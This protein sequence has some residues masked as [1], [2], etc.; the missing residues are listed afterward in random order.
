MRNALA[1]LPFCLF[2]LAVAVPV[3]AQAPER[4]D[5]FGAAIADAA[6]ASIPLPAPRLPPQSP[7]RSR[8]PVGVESGDSRE[9]FA[10]L[11]GAFAGGLAGLWVGCAIG[12]CTGDWIG[13]PPAALRGVLIG[14]P[15][16]AGLTVRGVRTGL[17]R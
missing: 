7:E 13:P 10:L 2:L 6:R 9:G 5:R 11:M 16:A 15:L 4:S 14:I 8:A 1:V 17:L 3:R 12:D